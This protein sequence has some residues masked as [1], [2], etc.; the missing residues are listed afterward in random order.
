MRFFLV[1]LSVS[2]LAFA[3]QG[4]A[5]QAA[6]PSTI[7]VDV[8]TSVPLTQAVVRELANYGQVR[9]KMWNLNM[10]DMRVDSGSLGRLRSLDIV[11]YVEPEQQVVLYERTPVSSSA[12]TGA[13]ADFSGGTSTWDMDIIDVTDSASGTRVV[14]YDGAGVYV[15]VVDTG[16]V[17]NWRDYFPA[18]RVDTELA[19]AFTGGA[20]ERSP[21][22]DKGRAANNDNKWDKDIDGHGTHVTSTILGYS[23]AGAGSSET[24]NGVAPKAT[25]IPVK[26]LNQNGY[27]S[28]LDIVAAL[29]YVGWLRE[30]GTVTAPIVVNMSLGVS[31][32]AQNLEDAI[33]YAISQGVIVVA[34]AGNEG[35]SGMGWPGAYPQVISAAASGWKG[36]WLPFLNRSFWRNDVP[37]ESGSSSESYITFFSSRENDSLVPGFDQELDVTAPGLWTLG[38]YLNQGAAH[39]PYWAQGQIRKYYFLG[40]TSMASPHVAGVA[41]LIMQKNPNLTQSQV[42]AI[43]T[44]SAL[45]IPA[46]TYTDPLQG[47]VNDWGTGADEQGTGLLQADGA[48]AATP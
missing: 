38:P 11:Q 46:G 16:L 35:T 26:V 21:W 34:A 44:S 47:F 4:S 13:V 1:A 30:S 3:F 8:K 15:A 23:F 28:N 20:N 18:D 19:T 37:E 24:V 48:L 32:P 10:V 39:P 29:Y 5:G 22:D 36:T 33:D 45:P 17:N 43:I 6:A 25:I 40:G 12:P 42:E 7:R 2:L 31:R 14:P 27:G 9:H 41:A